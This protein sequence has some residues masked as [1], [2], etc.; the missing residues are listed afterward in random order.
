MPRRRRSTR[1][2][3]RRRTSDACRKSWRRGSRSSASNT[4]SD[5]DHRRLP[6]GRLTT[7]RPRN[8]G[9][10]LGRRGASAVAAS[11]APGLLSPRAEVLPMKRLSLAL[12]ACLLVL[13]AAPAQATQLPLSIIHC[14]TADNFQSIPTTGGTCASNADQ[15]T[16]TFTSLGDIPVIVHAPASSGPPNGDFVH[17]V[18]NIV[19][20]T[21]VPWTDF[22]FLV[23]KIDANPNLQVNLL[24]LVLPAGFS[25]QAGLNSFSFFGPTPVGGTLHLVFDLQIIADQFSNNLFAVHEFP[26]VATP[27]PATLSL[28]GLGLAG[29]ARRARSR[30]TSHR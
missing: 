25:T 5:Y 23:Q 24:N 28:I 14:G 7:S 19:N 27:E 30:R 21:G 11:L 9:I 1:Q 12:F 4:R 20:N 10:L 15:I 13:F 22:H 8:N 6:T 17:V 16:K 29:L 3:R 26:S 2:R 18:E